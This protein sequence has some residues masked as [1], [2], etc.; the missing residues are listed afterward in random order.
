MKSTEFESQLAELQPQ[1]YQ[2]TKKFTRSREDSCDL[3]QETLA[4]A[5]RRRSDFR[6]NKNLMGWLYIIM[7]NT[8]IN[9]YRKSMQTKNMFVTDFR[10]KQ[11]DDRWKVKSDEATHIQEVWKSINS[12]N[13]E[14]RNPFKMHL[15]GYKYEEIAKEL[16][17]PI[18]TV[19]SRIF[20]IRQ[21]LRRLLP[22]YC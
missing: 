14:L 7:R 20:L 15:S 1:L 3:L 13:P 10:F 21:E 17:I 18:G 11:L 8:F 22:G 6:E 16:S 12:I 19:K 4:K 2:L 9:Q 5:W